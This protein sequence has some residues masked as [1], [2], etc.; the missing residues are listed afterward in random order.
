VIGTLTLIDPKPSYVNRSAVKLHWTAKNETSGPIEFGLLGITMNTGT[1]PSQFQSTRSGPN[2][3]LEPGEEIGADE[4]VRPLR[5][6]EQVEGEA[7]IVLSMCFS[8]YDDCEKPGADWE[9]ISPP[10]V[11]HI[12]P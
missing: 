8:K 12:V 9:N 7:V 5:F 6:G 10:I 1:G 3:K 11:I 4:I 2:N